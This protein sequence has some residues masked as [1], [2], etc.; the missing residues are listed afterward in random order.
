[1]GQNKKAKELLGKAKPVAKLME[2]TK[3]H[4]NW[5]DDILSIE[6][7]AKQKKESGIIIMLSHMTGLRTSE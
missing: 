1:M 5:F 3:N 4:I 6:S 7:S 2:G